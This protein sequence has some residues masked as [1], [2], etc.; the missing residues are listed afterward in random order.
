MKVMSEMAENEKTLQFETGTLSRAHNSSSRNRKV[1]LLF[2]NFSVCKEGYVYN[3]QR[4]EDQ[5]WAVK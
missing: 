1:K 3:Y 4:A 2:P 5:K